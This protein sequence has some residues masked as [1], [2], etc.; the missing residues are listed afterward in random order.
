MENKRGITLVAL[1]VTV[2]VLLILA[3]ISI[4]VL[5]GD[6]G[7]I[8]NAGEAKED[9]E[10]AEEKEMVQVSVESALNKNVLGNLIEEDFNKALEENIG[11][12]K[13]TLGVEDD[14]FKVT[15]VDSQRVY[16]VYNDGKVIHLSSEAID[17]MNT[18]QIGDYVDYKPQTGVTSYTFDKMYTGYSVNQTINQDNLE[19]RVFKIND[20]GTIEVIAATPTTQELSLK[21]A[22]GYNNGVYL[23]N[24][25]CKTVYSN[26]EKDAVARSINIEDIENKMDLS[27][28]D[29]HDS[30]AGT[31][32]YGQSSTYGISANIG[33]NPCYPYQW[34]QEKSTQNY[35]NDT[36]VTGNLTSS[37]QFELTTNTYTQL[38][39]PETMT[40]TQNGWFYQNFTQNNF[41]HP[42]YNELLFE[43]AK[44]Y[45]I[46]SR[47]VTSATGAIANFTLQTAKNGVYCFDNLFR[48]TAYPGNYSGTTQEQ[49]YET[50]T[51]IV[52][53][54]ELPIENVKK[55]EK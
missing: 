10:I 12:G 30:T 45:W 39:Y 26:S 16:F 34:S 4:S 19:W 40:V 13:Y 29:F 17:L 55:I 52:P 28:W 41:I 47:C 36:I 38:S 7:I 15:Y 1:V 24:D 11:K 23:L 42:K 21:G 33:R 20:D 25:F 51:N 46:A 32:T 6:N 3:A 44:T 18:L 9:T 37:E 27:V 35:I 31:G 48:N 53:I 54:V 5:R 2:V 43:G 50:R 22:L 49:E 8:G 14:R